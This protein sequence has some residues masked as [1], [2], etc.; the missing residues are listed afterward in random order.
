[1]PG[2]LPWLSARV[3]LIGLALADAWTMGFVYNIYFFQVSSR[4]AGLTGS[5]TAAIFTWLSL[6]YLMGRYSADTRLRQTSLFKILRSSLLVAGLLLSTTVLTTWIFNQ[7]DLRIDRGFLIPVIATTAIAST[8]FQIVLRRRQERIQ[9]WVLIVS[10]VEIRILE[11]ELN[12]EKS[13]QNVE[14]QLL[15]DRAATNDVLIALP[16]SYGLAISDSAILQDEVIEILLSKRSRGCNIQDLVSWTELHLQRVPPEIFSPRWLVNA[17][18]FRLQPSRLTWRFKRLGDLAIGALLLLAT[19]PIV[20]AS[21]IA[22]RLFDGGP[23]F[24]EQV[25]T[26]LYGQTFRI[27]K[28]RTMQVNSES[29]GPQWACSNDQRITAVG[30]WLRKLRIDELP[31]LISVL[32]GEMSLIGPRPERPEIE[33][34]LEEAIPHY[35]IRHWIRPGLSGWAQV[36][37]RYGASMSDSKSKLSYDLYYLRNATILLDILILLKTIRLVVRAVG[38][39]PR[40]S[41][42]Q[43]S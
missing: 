36:C 18:G 25:R 20:L 43:I 38:S 42:P 24:Y 34:G 3:N 33:Q 27:R 21:A 31:Q 23:V 8:G 4:W 13:L 40:P 28:L 2:R 1:V 6:S 30:H 17:E 26:G 10:Q 15:S 14:V 16:D 11:Q 37:Y 35:R 22:I 19:S 29:S 39:T 12:L 9:K 41:T 5:I 32:S 7:D